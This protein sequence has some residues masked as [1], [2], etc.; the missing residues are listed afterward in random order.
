M[1]SVQDLLDL[2][3]TVMVTKPQR[4]MGVTEGQL[5]RTIQ[6]GGLGDAALG[7]LAA[8]VDDPGEHTLGDEARRI[9]DDLHRYAI[10]AQGLACLRQH[11]RVERR[12]AHQYAARVEADEG[13]QRQAASRRQV[14]AG[15]HAA[16]ILAQ[17]RHQADGVRT[18]LITL[19]Q[20][21]AG[22]RQHRRYPL[23][24]C[25]VT[26]VQPKWLGDGHL[27]RRLLRFLDHTAILVAIEALPCFAPQQATGQTGW[28]QRRWGVAR[29]L[30]KLGVKRLHHRMGDVEADQVEQF[31]RPHAKAKAVLEDAIDLRRGG[32]P[33][34]QDTQCLR[35][36]G[37]PGMIDQETR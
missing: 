13:L 27:R 28:H 1:Q 17:R 9:I 7:N 22:N 18:G 8:Q 33:L 23:A 30:V 37:P 29:I 16:G 6:S 12:L 36:E 3:R 14:L 10:G 25:R 11:L 35:T 2:Q 26:A 5:H 20:H 15:D 31:E 21:H 34:A 4:A 19:F 32:N 24:H